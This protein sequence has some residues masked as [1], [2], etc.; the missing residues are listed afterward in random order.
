MSKVQD[1]LP[2]SDA[3]NTTAE[4]VLDL[5]FGPETSGRE[6]GG[7]ELGMD[8][9]AGSGGHTLLSRPSP[10]QGRRSLFRR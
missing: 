6:E 2:V 1:S 3:D 7:G 4:P 8:D 9:N 5:T 10:Q